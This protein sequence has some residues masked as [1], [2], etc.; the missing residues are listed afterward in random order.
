[1][2]K[3]SQAAANGQFSCSPEGVSD[4][5]V[6]VVDRYSELPSL[7]NDLTSS[8]C[9]TQVRRDTGEISF[10]FIHR[11]H[12]EILIYIIKWY[13]SFP[14]SIDSLTLIAISLKCAT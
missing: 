1:M 2:L 3:L 9:G 12:L 10:E 7:V 14:I 6:L 8:L 11:L 13:D 5:K 4:Q